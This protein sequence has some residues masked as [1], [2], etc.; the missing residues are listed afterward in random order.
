[1]LDDLVYTNK[2]EGGSMKV[3]K[4]AMVVIKGIKRNGLCYLFGDAA[5][6]KTSLP[7]VP[8]D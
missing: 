8:E 6:R 3:F 1:M 2:I 7:L 5:T 4:G